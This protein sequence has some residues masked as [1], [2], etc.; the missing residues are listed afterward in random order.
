MSL[1]ATLHAGHRQRL[2]QRF[3]QEGLE[4][5]ADHQVLELLLFHVVPRRDTNR[6]AHLLFQRFG[7]LSAVL[8]ADPRDLRTVEG[9]GEQAAA[10]LALIPQI[11]RRYLQD[12]GSREKPV[13]LTPQAVKKFILPLMIGR[14]EEVFYV[15]CLDLH[16][17]LL[18]PALVAQGTVQ[19][20]YIHPRLV[21]EEVIRHRASKVILAHNHPAESFRASASDIT[22]TRTL[23]NALQ[24][25]NIMVLDHLIVAGDGCLSMAEAGIVEFDP[26]AR[27]LRDRPRLPGALAE[28]SDETS[29]EPDSPSEETP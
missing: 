19:E 14:T 24:P 5:F 3:L 23:I 29:P 10:F 1:P 13:L 25:L 8:E 15:V 16:G 7:T 9:I 21:V 22:F 2:R 4:G 17:R 11:T 18:F 6:M 28:Q 20:T 27:D 26:Q 12:R